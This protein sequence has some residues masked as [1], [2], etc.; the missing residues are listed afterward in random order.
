VLFFAQESEGTQQMSR[1]APKHEFMNSRIIFL[2]VG[3]LFFISPNSLYPQP[4]RDVFEFFRNKELVLESTDKDSAVIETSDIE[5][6]FANREEFIL[7]KLFGFYGL[8]VNVEKGY[9]EILEFD[10]EDFEEIA[11]GVKT[12]AYITV[13]AEQILIIPLRNRNI[14]LR[15][16]AVEP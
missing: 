8:E 7:F 13:E 6:Y 12:P 9:I 10:F 15:I 2:F 14:E 16:R 4:V 1:I 11:R 3:A 5:L